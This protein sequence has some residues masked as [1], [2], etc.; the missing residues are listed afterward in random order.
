[1]A[2]LYATE[3]D[4]IAALAPDD[5]PE[6]VDDY[7]IAASALVRTATRMAIYDTTPAGYPADD[8]VADAFTNATLAQVLAWIDL[9][10]NPT[11]GTA[12]V[13][14]TVESSGIGSA[15]I[16]RAQRDGQGQ[17]RADTI[18]ALVPIAAAHLDQLGLLARQPQYR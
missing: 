14:G 6:N 18:T 5:P 16:K 13:T 8:E 10:I 1:M 7:L 15:N 12:G 3:A 17:D 4:L 2:L 11:T 9:G